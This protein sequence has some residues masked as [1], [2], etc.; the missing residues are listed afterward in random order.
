MARFSAPAPST[1]VSEFH[2]RELT[3]CQRAVNLWPDLMLRSICGLLHTHR[4]LMTLFHMLVSARTHT[5]RPGSW[6]SS[7]APAP[8]V[9]QRQAVAGSGTVEI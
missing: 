5:A 2:S 8:T 6:G 7:R 3:G 1:G 9:G 4:M